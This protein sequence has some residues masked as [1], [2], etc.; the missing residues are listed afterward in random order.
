MNDYT[1]FI[2][3][4]LIAGGAL[5]VPAAWRLAAPAH[6]APGDRVAGPD[7]GA[8]RFA[9]WVAAASAAMAVSTGPGVV[10]AMLA[11]PWLVV[12]AVGTGQ[13]LLAAARSWPGPN[14][15]DGLSA[16]AVRGWAVVAGVALVDSCSGTGA[17]GFGEPII[18]LTAVHFTYAGVATTTLAL[19]ARRAVT[20]PTGRPPLASSWA[21]GL[22]LAAPPIVG[23][24]F[25]TGAAVPQVGGAVLMTVGV[26]VLSA[27]HLLEGW[28][29]RTTGA[30]RLLLVSGASTWGPMAVAV[31]WA[32]AQ[33]TGGPALS[34][35]DLVR[36]HGS[37]N[38]LGF[39]GCGLAARHLLASTA[40]GSP[41]IGPEPAAASR[42]LPADIGVVAGR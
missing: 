15:I 29:R 27:R 8:W 33:H 39:V 38:A 14:G 32:L 9:W 25:V 7:L 17:L 11:L 36:T 37:L 21:L 1:V 10:A 28:R 2:D 42:P 30:G 6:D 24:G 26:Y 22:V 34:I 41:A 19:L 35:P 18:R 40:S 20:P 5:V 31:A 16:I 3:V 12:A 13:V 23:A 4:S